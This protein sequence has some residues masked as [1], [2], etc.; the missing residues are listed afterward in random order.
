MQGIAD[1]KRGMDI[2]N[3]AL[4]VELLLCTVSVCTI[5]YVCIL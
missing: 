3:R 2:W 1:R 4:L 5:A